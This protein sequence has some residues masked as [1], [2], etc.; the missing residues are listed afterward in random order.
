MR[1]P[2]ESDIRTMASGVAEELQETAGIDIRVDVSTHPE[3][4]KRLADA[5]AKALTK[6]FSL[7]N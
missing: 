2:T 6:Y 1:N 7:E 4:M 5:V 3:A